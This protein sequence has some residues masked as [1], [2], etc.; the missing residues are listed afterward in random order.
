MLASFGELAKGSGKDP[1]LA[2]IDWEGPAFKCSCPSRKF[3]CKHGLALLLLLAEQ[4]QHIPPDTAPDWVATWIASRE[5]RVEKP[6]ARPE[7]TDQRLH[8]VSE[9]LELLDLWLKDLVQQGLSSAP[10]R[11]FSFW[12]QQ[13]ARLIDAQAP[14]VARRVRDLGGIVLSGEGWHDRMLSALARLV[15]IIQGF[16]RI[17]KLA[18][19]VQADLRTAIGL[20][21]SHADV[22]ATEPVRDHWLVAGQRIYPED[23]MRV[24]RTWLMGD[25][26]GRIAML[27]DFAVGTTGFKTNLLPRTII[28]ADLCF[29][30][31]A[32]PLRALVKEVTGNPQPPKRLIHMTSITEAFQRIGSR[33]AA[34]PWTEVH[35]VALRAV[36]PSPQTRHWT[37]V[38][39]FGAA[40]PCHSDFSLLALSGGRP[41]DIFG[42]WDGNLLHVLGSSA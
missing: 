26:T 21:I 36:V 13:A 4:P 2:Q 15:L 27:L 18:P 32:T 29:F 3:P 7:T 39:E 22:L 41:V 37:L 16:S 24:Q 20:P 11:G 1:Y 33:L 17:D 34:N 9:G 38:D 31:S 10:S 35:P 19:D 28:Q 42:E 8:R 40:M 12:D 5:K 23:R 6:A 14:G 30:P 25:K